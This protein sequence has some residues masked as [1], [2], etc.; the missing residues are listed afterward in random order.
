MYFGANVSYASLPVYLPTILAKMGYSN[1][2]AQGLSAPPYFVAFLSALI[3]TW[4]ADKTQQRGLMLI[5]TSLIG[6][7]GY[8]ILATVTTVGVR[9]F[10]VF[11]AA[12]G[13][14]STIPNI[15]AW[16]L[17]TSS[18]QFSLLTTP[19]SPLLDNQ[20]SD[21]RRGAG[22]VLINVV[23]QCGAVLSSRIYPTSE[24]PRFVK[25]QSICAAFMFFTTLLAFTL[26]FL[27]VWNNK[28]LDREQGERPVAQDKG[29][30][31][32]VENY[33]P[34]FRYVL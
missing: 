28:K 12:S 34:N 8:I 16:T 17:S 22:L 13:V 10:A 23:G 3:T 1:I 25:G 4:I 14:F 5:A 6:G 9:Y 24:S 21:T 26:R 15:L 31:T 2:H 19:D 27:L 18:P 32:A 20:G 11:L 30:A 29:T 33:G 7:T